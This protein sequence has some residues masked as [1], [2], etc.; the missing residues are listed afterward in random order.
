[1]RISETKAML[2]ALRTK[3]VSPA[4]MYNTALEYVTAEFATKVA[5]SLIT[6]LQL[7]RSI[8]GNDGDPNGKSQLEAWVQAEMIKQID[9]CI[10]SAKAAFQNA[11]SFQGPHDG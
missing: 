4:I 5:D 9:G 6:A 8:V 3:T 7:A 2:E 11:R 1:M 10:E